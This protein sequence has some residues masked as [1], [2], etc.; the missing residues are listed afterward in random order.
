MG[1]IAGVLE[2]GPKI[3]PLFGYDI[4]ISKNVGFFAM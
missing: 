1:F 3:L 2:V 4:A